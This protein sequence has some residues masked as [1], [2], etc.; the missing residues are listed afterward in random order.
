MILMSKEKRNKIVEHY[1]NKWESGKF[2]KKSLGIMMR[3]FHI[4]T[5]IYFILVTLF[6]PKNVVWVVLFLLVIILLMFFIFDGCILSMI[7]NRVC[8]DD[9][10]IADP[11]LE[12][13][14]WEK[15]SKN[16]F[17]VTLIVGLTYYIMVGIIYY[18]RFL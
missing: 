12:A 5:P 1:K 14:E 11:Y 8:N 4:S 10:T 15:N 3:S 18:I 17:N 2:S 13:L 9:F 16:R 6:A 7:E